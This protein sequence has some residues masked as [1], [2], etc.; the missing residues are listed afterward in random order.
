MTVRNPI[1]LRVR[2]ISGQA[3]R[4]VLVAG[5]TSLFYLSLVAAGLAA[6]VHYFVAILI[7]QGITILC[8]F[9]FYR[10]FVFQ[11][12]SRLAVDFAR[13]VGVWSTGA[14]AGLVVT[15]LLVEVLMWHPL[16]AQIVA[17]VVVSVMSFLGH[18]YFSF[19]DTSK[20]DKPSRISVD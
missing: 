10:R 12:R 1:P 11:S 18:R 15:P 19:R 7:A 17:I 16:V 8:A 3:V 14:I 13:F 20:A 5:T 6:Q 9:P 2:S 4:Y